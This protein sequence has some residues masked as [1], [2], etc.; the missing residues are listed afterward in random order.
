[1]H[2]HQYNSSGFPSNGSPGALESMT[3]NTPTSQ[4][5]A[6]G[7]NYDPTSKR[8]QTISV[9]GVAVQYNYLPDSNQVYQVSAGPARMHIMQTNDNIDEETLYSGVYGYNQQDQ[10]TS[11]GIVAAGP[12]GTIQHN[13]VYGYSAAN[14]DAL[15]SVTDNSQVAAQYS[16]DGAGNFTSAWMGLGTTNVV[17]QYSSLTYDARGNVTTDVTVG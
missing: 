4:S 2:K 13:Y 3:V 11:E 15:T 10:M 12:N 14:A 7:Y 1:M 5:A 16:F 9:N 8:L 17:N 6:T